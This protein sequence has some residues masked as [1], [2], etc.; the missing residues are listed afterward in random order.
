MTN[1]ISK[2]TAG[3][4]AGIAVL[5]GAGGAVAAS[6]AGS[7]SFL[8]DVAKRLGVSQDALEKAIIGARGDEVDRAL[9]DGKITEEQAKELKSRLESGDV[10]PGFGPG[11]GHGFGHR[12]FGHHGFGGLDG[13]ATYLG[14]TEAEL[15]AALMAGKS[16]AAIAKEEGKS[17]DGL[18]QA[19]VEEQKKRLAA[20]VKDGRLTQAQADDL[21]EGLADR[22]DDL[23]ERT[24]REH[25]VRPAERGFGGFGGPPAMGDP[26]Q[27]AVLT[28]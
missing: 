9:A 23:V 21:A 20:A 18:K 6:T 26:S 5:V 10:G 28:Y 27:P 8:A 4:V 17:V 22:V 25:G 14:V 7:D 2:R 15:R 11:F 1:R 24:P 16:L 12:G 13:A 3:V 19:I